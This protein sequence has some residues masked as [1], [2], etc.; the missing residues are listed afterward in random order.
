MSSEDCIIDNS[1][2]YV[3]VHVITF[4]CNAE[5]SD[6]LNTYNLVKHIRTYRNCMRNTF[7]F[8]NVSC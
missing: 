6:I 5:C 8:G 7:T 1:I 4:D 2:A 3:S